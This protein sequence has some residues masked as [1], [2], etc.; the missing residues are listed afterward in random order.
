[1]LIRIRYFGHFR[2]KFQKRSE[3]VQ[4]SKNATLYNLLIS[5]IAKYGESF[6]LHIFNPSST[7][8]SD[9][10]LLNI[11]GVPSSQLKGLKTKLNNG[12]EIDIMPLFSGG[13]QSST[14]QCI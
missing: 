9:D 5:L 13:G 10:V 3:E 6:K 1:M 14:A 2:M 11:N 7:G 4:M 12:D 8:L